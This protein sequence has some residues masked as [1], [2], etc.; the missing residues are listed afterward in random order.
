MASY[1]EWNVALAEYFA[2]GVPRGA[3]VYL[4]VDEAALLDIGNR[5]GDWGECGEDCVDDFTRAV[6]ERC[7]RGQRVMLDDI[8]NGEVNGIP[9]CVAFLGAMVLAAHWMEA[10]ADEDDQISAINYF[11]RLRQ[12]LGLGAESGGR[13][14]GLTPAGVEEPLWREWNRWLVTNGWM[15]S[16]I[17]GT[18][19]ADKF[20]SLPISQSL[21]REGDK[22]K[23]E[24]FLRERERAN[25]ISRAW[26]K[27]QLNAWLRGVP[28]ALPSHHL[29]LLMREPDARRGE[30]I[31]DAFFDVYSTIDWSHD[32]NAAPHEQNIS[33]QRKLTAGLYRT[34]DIITGEIEYALYPRQPR[35][36]RG[37]DLSVVKDGAAHRLTQ[38]CA[39]WFSPLWIV[40]PRG[41][42][43]YEVR[44]SAQIS[45]LL[46]PERRFWILTRDP[47]NPEAGVFASWKP[48]EVGESFLLLCHGDY[49]EQMGILREEALLNWHNEHN[50]TFGG[51]TWIEYRECMVLTQHW[52]GVLPR[53]Q[54]QDLYE[55]LKPH[56]TASIHLTG[57]LRAPR[58]GAWLAGYAPQIKV[59][60]F[61]YP[62][63]LDIY[64]LHDQEEP[65]KDL[66]VTSEKLED[67]CYSL[68]AGDYLLRVSARSGSR[69]TAQRTLRV[70]EWDELEACAFDEATSTPFAAVDFSQERMASEAG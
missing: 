16:A 66:M 59:S 55:A 24:V 41:G 38:E 26:D 18:G 23:L 28:E 20:V 7:V 40:D 4:G 53:P 52:E 32:V 15:P 33:L 56:A 22:G 17:K 48:P 39:G 11:K 67:V 44:G 37:D 27:D 60:A 51:D 25:R 19:I 47:E 43:Q 1:E 63:M 50:L 9:S 36:W 10:E 3:S 49:A 62:V 35:R 65:L 30:A 61:E 70:I 13:P 6:R 45:E 42:E 57:G 46:L 34:E 29:K 58:Q 68:D 31:A 5:F 69:V 21:M 54:M 8:E 12:V 64:D 2:A 14:H